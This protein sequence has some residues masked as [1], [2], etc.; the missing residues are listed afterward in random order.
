[1]QR[2]E[3]FNKIIYLAIA[4]VLMLLAVGLVAMAA[5]T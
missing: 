1:M 5:W 2:F 3:F 4:L